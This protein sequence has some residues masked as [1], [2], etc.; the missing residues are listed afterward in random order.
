MS[1]FIKERHSDEAVGSERR[2]AVGA[3]GSVVGHPAL[4]EEEGEGE[5]GK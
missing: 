5:G 4:G 2:S 3:V 1:E